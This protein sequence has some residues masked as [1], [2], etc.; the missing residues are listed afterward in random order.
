M[1]GECEDCSLGENFPGSCGERIN[2]GL[3]GLALPLLSSKLACGS[4]CGD[5]YWNE[6]MCDPPECCDPC[7]E[8]GCWVGPQTCPPRHGFLLAKAYGIGSRVRYGLRTVFSVFRCGHCGSGRCDGHCHNAMMV[9]ESC[10]SCGQVGCDGG[11]DSFAGVEGAMT[12]ADLPMAEAPAGI[13]TQT[14]PQHVMSGSFPKTAARQIFQN[15]GRPPHRV[16]S[17]RIR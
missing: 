11:C 5:V 16:V 2:S 17:R 1:C 6:W 14:R 7:D 10:G 8:Y 13:V 3:T 9:D 15:H 12:G 4:G